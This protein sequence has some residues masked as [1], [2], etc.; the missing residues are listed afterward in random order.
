LHPWEF[1]RYTLR[2]L[3]IKVEVYIDRR[4]EQLNIAEHD[5]RERWEQTRQLS[6]HVVNAAGAKLTSVYQLQ[7]FP[8]DPEP[9]KS[10]I[11]GLLERFP[12]TLK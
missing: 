3:F 8:W 10:K 11:K 6:F 4:D 9:E 12:K 1:G 2:D 7:K 5:I